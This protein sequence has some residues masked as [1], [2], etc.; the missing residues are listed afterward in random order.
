MR[1]VP[2]VCLC[3]RLRPRSR[4]AP[5]PL[6]HAFG[7]QSRAVLVRCS[8]H[9]LHLL[10]LPALDS[11][12]SAACRERRRRGSQAIRRLN[13]RCSTG[14]ASS[15]TRS[16]ADTP[17]KRSPARC[18]S[19]APLAAGC[20]SRCRSRPR[21]SRGRP[22]PLSLCRRRRRG[23]GRGGGGG[24]GADPSPRGGSVG[25]SACLSAGPHPREPR[26]PHPPQGPR[27]RA[28]G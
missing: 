15:T 16:R 17:P 1:I 2:R 11:D 20:G 7:R 23:L 5:D 21:L 18:S 28:G 6:R 25:R 4:G 10:W 24:G 14:R 8:G 3:Q 27:P 22:R 26:G 19:S 12:P 9:R 13:E